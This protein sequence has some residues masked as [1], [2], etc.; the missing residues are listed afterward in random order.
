MPATLGELMDRIL[1]GALLLLGVGVLSVR[2][3][4]QTGRAP[5]N[6]APVQV[7]APPANS[8]SLVVRAS[9][10]GH[11]AVEARVDGRR[12]PFMIDTGA[13][14][15]TIR[16]SDAARL[17]FHPKERDYSVRINTAN[18]AGRAAQVDL[19]MVEVG[20]IVV[21][22]LPALII[23]DNMLSVNLLGMTFLSRLR[24]SHERG[25]LMLE[26]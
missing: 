26:Q 23:P 19:R 1:F 25:K 5:V 20:D 17:G 18:G 16:E 13:S 4:D 2:Y 7:A 10:G 11:F 22:D 24:W 9:A 12:I 14:Q 15:I 21:R 3:L 6:A 8:R